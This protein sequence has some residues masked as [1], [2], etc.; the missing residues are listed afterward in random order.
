MS[1][2]EIEEYIEGFELHRKHLTMGRQI[3][4]LEACRKII[5]ISPLYRPKYHGKGFVTDYALENVNC[6]TQAWISD[7]KGFRYSPND[8][9]GNPLQPIPFEIMEVVKEFAPAD[10]VAENCL[11]NFY[12]DRMEYGK[13]KKSKLGLH[14]DRTEKDLT[15][16]IFSISIGQ[17]ALFQIGGLERTDPVSEIELN[18][19]DVVVMAGKARNAFHGVK[20]LIPRSCPKELG[21]K[22]EARI[23]ITVRQVNPIETVSEFRQKALSALM[24]LDPEKRDEFQKKFTAETIKELEI[25]MLPGMGR[26]TKE[27]APAKALTPNER[28]I[29]ARY[30]ESKGQP[31]GAAA[32][33]NYVEPVDE[34]QDV[35]I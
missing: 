10:F 2:F 32:F 6:G 17:S 8:I 1:L 15:A 20:E 27:E 28:E 12:K 31:L 22:A 23:N 33:R 35:K 21:M 14:Q 19:G 29:Y 13:L 18:S 5:K 26:R 25:K 7:E 11:I 4:I 9:E 3:Q 16:P 30:L 34:K 24:E